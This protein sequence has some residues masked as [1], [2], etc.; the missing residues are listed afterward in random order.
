MLYLDKLVSI[1][2]QCNIMLV[3]IEIGPKHIHSTSIFQ[4]KLQK[5]FN[6]ARWKNGYNPDLI[7]ASSSIDSMLV[8][9]VLSPIPRTQHRPYLCH[10]K[11]CACVATY[12]IQKTFNPRKAN[13]SGYATD[14]AIL[15]DEVDPTLE[16]GDRF[17]S[18][19]RVAPN[20]TA[21]T[22]W[23][24]HSGLA[25]SVQIVSTPPAPSNRVPITVFWA[26]RPCG[27]AG[28]AGNAPHKRGRC[29][30]SL[31]LRYLPQT[32]IS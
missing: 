10:C 28:L 12:C 23:S 26:S 24:C 15:I 11:P 17:V 6:S 32:N 2:T 31:D 30:T 19:I 14:V 20:D 25:N 29:Q 5:C 16:N 21:Y 4:T 27:L 1:S 9:Y 13:W 8:K 7:F 3:N 22:Q 18:A